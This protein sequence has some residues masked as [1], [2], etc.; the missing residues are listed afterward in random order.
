MATA[1][2]P[3]AGRLFPNTRTAAAARTATSAQGPALCRRRQSW[4]PIPANSSRPCIPLPTLIHLSPSE[5][6]TQETDTPS[7]VHRAPQQAILTAD[8]F[9]FV[10]DTFWRGGYGK[11]VPPGLSD[12]HSFLA[13]RAP[14][15]HQ[16]R[17]G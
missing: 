15:A 9:V 5:N 17:T 3:N 13:A 10:F 12:G 4:P 7:V 1:G 6:S 2:I 16:S 11:A 14:E 8:D